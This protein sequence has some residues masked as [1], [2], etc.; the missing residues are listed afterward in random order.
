[1][2][3]Y[4]TQML[5]VNDTH[6][7]MKANVLSV[8]DIHM[9]MKTNLSFEDIKKQYEACK[10]KHYAIQDEDEL[11]IM[12][13]EYVISQG[14]VDAVIQFVEQ[15]DKA[16]YLMNHRGVF[17]YSGNILHSCL[18]WN[19][20]EKGI[21][22]FKH[23]YEK[24]VKIILDDYQC[25]PWQQDFGFWTHPIQTGLIGVRDL[26]EFEEVYHQITE[27]MAAQP[28]YKIRI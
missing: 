23:F 1:M 17:R 7:R 11:L 28:N 12:H 20:G 18:Y 19:N 5:S 15:S 4:P 10:S 25:V 27:Y 14:D 16:D 21:A 6:P 2:T 8:N 3:A 13:L 26:S 24:G 9:R 22:L